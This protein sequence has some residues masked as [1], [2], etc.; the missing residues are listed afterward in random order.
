MVC[1]ICD[2]SKDNKIFEIREMM[3]GYR[4]VFSY[5]QCSKC[6]C[7][8]IQEF[9]RDLVKYYP[10]GY[11]SYTQAPQALFKNPLKNA[12]RRWRDRYAVFG[13]NMLGKVLYAKFPNHPLRSLAHIQA[14]TKQTRILDV[15]CGSGALLYILK[16]NGFKNL[17]GID[18]IIRENLHY[19]NGLQILKRNIHE[20]RGEWD[21]IMWHHVFEHIPDPHDSLC[22][23]FKLLSADGVC[24]IRTPTTS[25]FAW[26]HYGVNWVQLDAPR[27]L[28]IHSLE[29]I[30][31]LASQARMTVQKTVYDSDFFQF[32]GSEQYLKNI[33]LVSEKSYG[34][35]P[36]G[37]IFSKT[38]IRRFKQRAEHLNRENRGDTAAFYLTKKQDSFR[39]Q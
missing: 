38:D 4:D 3:L 8:Q 19:P 13:K 25:S 22:S 7:L 33:P 32:W 20:M 34:M 12:V 31:L 28:F 15:G 29:S 18:P 6:G 27:H 36:A 14:L 35:N 1:R 11:F 23:I 5:F 16:K 21:L 9:P 30:N 2:N 26:E 39:C 10:A 24:V 17:I 37:S